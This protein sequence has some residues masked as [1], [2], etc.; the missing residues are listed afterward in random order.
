[1]LD[2]ANEA[3]RR[4]VNLY[5]Y[6]EYIPVM[7]RDELTRVQSGETGFDVERWKE[8]LEKKRE[9]IDSRFEAAYKK[10]QE[11]P[12]NNLQVEIDQST[13]N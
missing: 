13:N 10:Q 9:E 12:A 5:R 2:V 3:F 4:I 7:T 11:K 1:M 6:E 8:L